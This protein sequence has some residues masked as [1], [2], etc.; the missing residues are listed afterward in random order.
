MI[1]R[2]TLI[3][4][5]LLLL[6]A[7]GI[8]WMLAH[9]DLLT[10]ES[11]GPAVLALGFWAPI[12]FI[13][14]YAAATVLFFSGAI[15]SL[16]GGALFGPIWGTA[17]NL[18]GA[19]LG[20]TIAFLLARTV[21]GEWVARRVGGRLRSLAEGV[22][23]EGWR[24]VALMRLVPLV[25]FNLLNYALGLT[26]VSLP[27]Y[28]L[29]SAVCMLVL[30]ETFLTGRLGPAA[31]LVFWTLCLLA[32]CGAIAGTIWTAEA[33]VPTTPTRWPASLA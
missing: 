11:I 10:P 3:R 1:R 30:G 17:W 27:A 31:T 25:P 33:P 13:L 12:G 19:T 18:A 21:A 23:A 20:A 16:V 24:F 32:T 22:T 15:L 29:A 5:A 28:V 14:V 7:T 26:G 9:R 6:L 8:G 4:L 2:V